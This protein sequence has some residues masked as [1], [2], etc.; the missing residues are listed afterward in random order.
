MNAFAEGIQSTLDALLRLSEID[1]ALHRLDQELHN[2]PAALGTIEAEIRGLRAQIAGVDARRAEAQNVQSRMESELADVEKRRRRARERIA[3]LTTAQQIAT[4]ERE[5]DDLGVQASSLESEV[6]ERLDALDGI[7]AE[8]K[9]LGAR[10]GEA[11]ARLAEMRQQWIERGPVATAERSAWAARREAAVPG[12]P[13]EVLRTYQ[14]GL[15]DRRFSPPSGLTRID[16]TSCH[17]C[18][19]RPPPL[20]LQESRQRRA[21]HACEGC[22]RILMVDPNPSPT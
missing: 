1:Y 22:R 17:I 19:T 9:D 6:L 13:G 20:W 7:D 4:T 5:I 10:L 2:V 3:A 11:E 8:G 21:I 15:G 14:I 18:H 16:G 12:I